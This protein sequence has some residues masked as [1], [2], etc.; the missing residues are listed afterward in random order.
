MR[1]LLLDLPNHHPGNL[2][3]QFRGDGGRH[4]VDIPVRIDFDDIR[5]DYVALYGLNQPE[6]FAR[7][8]AAGFMVGY[9][10]CIGG[11]TSM[12]TER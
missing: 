12:S 4:A 5:P 11:G 2:L 8:H 6:D 7:G 1:W 3:Y 10:R 9:T